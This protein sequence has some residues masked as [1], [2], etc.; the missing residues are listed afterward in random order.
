MSRVGRRRYHNPRAAT[1]N[2]VAAKG[3]FEA[4]KTDMGLQKF[5]FQRFS[6]FFCSVV[7]VIVLVVVVVVVLFCL[8]FC[9]VLFCFCLFV[10]F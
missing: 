3:T 7:V 10:L 9:F 4:A 6:W 2:C 8:V 5:P 1:A